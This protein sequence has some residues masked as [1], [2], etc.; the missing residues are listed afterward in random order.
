MFGS[1]AKEAVYFDAFVELAT[2]SEE[3]GRAV[4][5]MFGALPADQSA[6][7]TAV[8]QLE[9]SADAVKGAMIRR[10]RENWI[11]PLD[12]NDI[13]E[14]ITLLDSV[15]DFVEAVADRIVLFEVHDPPSAATDL[16]K[17]LVNTTGKIV[18]ALKLLRDRKR[19]SEMLA[20]CEE[21]FKLETA[22]DK[23]YRGALAEL[24]KSPEGRADPLRVM[25][26]REIFDSLEMAVDRCQ[27]VARVIQG[28]VLEY[29]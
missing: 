28:V 9:T 20:L 6:A 10:L 13:H 15:L 27:D 1:A 11:T 17:L 18:A 22:A 4:V 7:A 3:A 5:Q 12:R 19:A 24:F 23:V 8:K 14:L 29:A 2:K 16:A 26:W 21:V 25:K